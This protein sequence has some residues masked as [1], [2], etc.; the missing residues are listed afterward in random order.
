MTFAE[1]S[2]EGHPKPAQRVEIVIDLDPRAEPI[3]GRV[4]ATDTDESFASWL[5]L[6]VALE[7][8]V[9]CVKAGR[10]ENRNRGSART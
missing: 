10:V 1:T 2:T 8:A 7:S 9:D 4:R 5:G 6:L 3:A